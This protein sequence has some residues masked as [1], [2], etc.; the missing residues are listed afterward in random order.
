LTLSGPVDGHGQPD[1][2]ILGDGAVTISGP[3]SNLQ[4][5]LGK[6]GNGTLTLSGDNTFSGSLY[7][8]KGTVVLRG[9]NAI[10]DQSAVL[11][12][13]YSPHTATLRLEA[14]ETIGSMRGQNSVIDLGK[15]TLRINQAY[16]LAYWGT[17]IGAGTLVKAGPAP[18]ELHAA[19]SHTGGTIIEAGALKV[20]ADN[21]LGATSASVSLNGGTLQWTG[22][23]GGGLDPNRTLTLSGGKSVANGVDANGGV[24]S[25]PGPI[26][27]PGALTKV[28]AG[29]VRLGNPDNDYTGG[30]RITGGAIQ[31]D[32]PEAIAGS[33]PNVLS[34]RP[35]VSASDQSCVQRRGGSYRGL[36][37]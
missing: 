32:R 1:L 2:Q 30:T 9:G 33:E 34:A 19:N 36:L 16:D 24:F 4:Q 20:R 26:T 14:D 28:G 8:E 18:L 11:L 5:T 6:R 7:L 15:F 25:I 31:F 27:G 35:G 10:A 17:F 12:E 23:T 3:I 37:E 29:T 21:C 13:V 22:G